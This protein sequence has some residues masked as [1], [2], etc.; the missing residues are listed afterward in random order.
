[1][2]RKKQS[3]NIKKSITARSRQPKISSKIKHNNLRRITFW[4]SSVAIVLIAA[5]VLLW[6]L[7]SSNPDISKFKVSVSSPSVS[8]FTDENNMFFASQHS[9]PDVNNDRTITNP[10]NLVISYSLE[11]GN[12]APVFKMNLIGTDLTNKIKISP[13]IKGTWRLLGDNALMLVPEEQWPAD[14]K[15]TVKIS[16]ELFNEDASV[17]EKR[18]TFTTPEITATVDNFNVY[19]APEDKK[20]VIGV[21]VIS[22]DYEIDTKD[23]EDKVSLKLDD[24]KLN[25]TVKF[26]RFHRTA[27]IISAPVR[28]TDNAQVMRIKL[29][30]VSALDGNSKTKKLT[31]NLTIEAADNIFKTTSVETTIAD[32]ND[33]NAQQL[34]LV[35]TTTA[36][37]SEKNLSEYISAYLLPQYSNEEDKQNNVSHDWKADEITDKVLSESKQLKLNPMNFA[38]PA[39]EHRY[40]FSYDVSEKSKR[41][42]YV[43]IKSGA[44]SENGFEMKNGLS[45][46][47]QIPYPTPSV[48]IAGS[49]ALLSLAGE[50]KLG[51]MAQGGVDTAYVNLYKVKSEEVNHLIT[52]TYN[53]FAQK[54]EFTSWSFGVYDMSVV[55]QKKISFAN[56]SKKTTNY[57]SV[58]LGDYLDRTYGDNTGIFIIQTGTSENSANYN[59]KRLILLT[60]LGIVRKVNL[61]E[62][63]D[64]FV[65]KLSTGTP[66]A[67]VEISVL[68]RNGNDVWAGRT[69]ED[70]HVE[71][72]ALPWSEYNNAREPVAIVARSGS[73]ISFIPYSAYNQ[74]VEY[75]KFDI[76]GV[77]SSSSTP[78]NA[79][80]FSDRGIYRPGEE[81]VLGGIV[82]NK[83]FQ[84]LAGIPVKM[85]MRDSRGRI[86]LEK[87]FSLTADGMFD[88]KYEIP[89]DA[90]LG[91]WNAYLY[92]LT[93]TNKL[94]DMLGTTNFDIQEFVPDTMKITANIIG[95]SESGWI[96]PDN[97]KASVSLRNLFG[98]PATNR[99]ISTR[100]ILTPIDYSF[101]EFKG[102][103]FTPNFISGTGLSDSTARSTKTY[104]VE[105]PDVKT[106]SNGTATIDV[107]FDQNIP[108]GTY[109]LSLNVQ[110]F[111]ANSGQS[112]QT[113]IS[114]R[115]S[116][117]KYLVGWKSSAGLD[118]INK[119]ASRK[120]DIIAVDHTA[121]TISVDGLKLRI[122]KQE[123]QTS[124][125]KDYNNYYKYQTVT[126][127]DI[128]SITPLNVQKEGTEINL[129]TKN[130]GTYFMQILDASDKIL[131]NVKYYIAGETNTA[132]ETDTKAELQIKLDK[133]EY[134]PG[135]KISVSITAPYTGAGLITIER[136]K[137]YAYKWFNAKTTSSVQNITLPAGF[138]GTGYVNVS[139]VRDI[140]SKDIFTTP[141]AYAVAP[142]A[143]DTSARKIG[144]KLEVPEIIEDGKL[145]VKYNTNKNARMMIFAINTGIL[146]VAKYQ[147]PNPLAHFFQKAALQVHTFQILSLLLPEYNLLQEYAQTG[148]G[149]Y[150]G[151]EGAINQILTNPFGRKTLPPVAFY[152]NIIDTKAN[153]P[154]TVNF[155][156][157]EYFNGSIKVFAVA[158]NGSAV[159]SAD[160]EAV[161]QSP[162]IVS[163]SAPTFVAPGDKFSVNSVITNMTDGENAEA[164]ISASATNGIELTSNQN[165]DA[166]IS[167]DTEKLITF[168]ARANN[169]LGNSDLTITAS[170]NQETRSATNTISVRPI[171]TY[172]TNIKSD[173]ISS[174]DT[175]ISKFK[176]DLYPEHATQRLYISQG[177]SALIVP[178]FKYLENYEYPCTEQLVSRAIPYAVLPNDT[179][180]GTKFDSSA[181]IINNTINTLKNRQNDNGSFALWAGGAISYDNANDANTAYLT[182]YVVQFLKIAKDAGFNVP[183]DMLSRSLDFL[184]TFAGGTITDD[185]Y[186]AATAYS[187]YVISENGFVTTSYI[188]TLTEYADANIKNWKSEL[189][190]AYIAASYKI[191]KQD[192]LARNLIS[193]Y[194]PSDKESFA[195]SNLFNN[196]VANDAMYYYLM[197]KYFESI[198]STSSAQ[199]KSYIASGNYSAYTSAIA[200]LGLSGLSNDKTETISS[201][202]VST[203]S[204]KSIILSKNDAIIYADIP[205]DATQIQITCEKCSKDNQVFY[206]LLQQGY[207][208]TTKETSNGIEIIREY[209]DAEGN[210]ITSANIGDIIT[211]KIYARTRSGVENAD[212][213]VITDLLPG[214]FIPNTESATGDMEFIEMREDRVL[215][216]TDLNREGKEFSYT[217]QIG[218]AGTFTVPAI[219]AESMYNPEINA[220]GNTGNFKAINESTEK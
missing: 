97:L 154:G 87:A 70:G 104:S 25:F 186:A 20:S 112:V 67:D 185:N 75:S 209:Y 18:I 119:N 160:T 130:S 138:E 5:A 166:T 150:A 52:Q 187:I 21:A 42:I 208:T 168:D 120:V 26:D 171:S 9:L 174:K 46:I 153:V 110:G 117:A 167:N 29:N 49:G 199:I 156:I 183:N 217:A 159:G 53:V 32:D 178:L 2:Q 3:K 107:K 73:D 83:K 148:G 79:F 35:N 10:S 177:A 180:L 198:D 196:S 105:L 205:M 11:S 24:E 192:D 137:V 132:L 179:I 170:I 37:Q 126:R 101:E 213:V 96:A 113:N 59:D 219:H 7:F 31:A 16:D 40:A 15:F 141:Y 61:D 22:F 78:M 14:T 133:A 94:D 157:P 191:L 193:Q 158:A 163:T 39:G 142:F 111:E 134:A 56:T 41:Y 80:M 13:F 212:N 218:T 122:I 1:M 106:D 85:Q 172:M 43:Q 66:A 203:D 109:K 181:K 121:N 108:T 68:G 95:S 201:I 139:F 55:F 152:S 88:I 91:N 176:I 145:T 128:I 210:K 140:N 124:L 27:F 214:G 161:V 202:A 100:A 19:S 6:N 169:T 8:T 38:T 93:S 151:D 65:S 129:D 63:S 118:Y 48:K 28:I 64:V 216:Y 54:M 45:T 194:E 84:S 164:K 62:T 144:I 74:Q 30:R 146:Q 102:Y 60:D 200:I 207:P 211:V 86:V 197:N 220:T 147:I 165:T 33:G 195:Y 98:T 69:D 155:D 71:I 36:A 116:D 206:T 175:K 215:I 17:D 131:A 4:I 12:Y 125:V 81:L 189:M 51:I 34:I 99:N 103:K 58:D 143:A 136:D 184:R 204:D 123:N 135:E 76:D 47:L 23:F 57:A 114:T 89:A 182:A 82:K 127:N 77:Y 50:R 162:V 149:D 90:P 44:K 115:V 188:D 92:S 190:G 173:V 72:P